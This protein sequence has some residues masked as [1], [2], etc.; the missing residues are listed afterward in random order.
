MLPIYFGAKIQILIITNFQIN[1]VAHLV[2]LQNTD[3]S[4]ILKKKKHSKNFVIDDFVCFQIS[5]YLWCYIQS[6]NGNML[7]SAGCQKEVYI[8]V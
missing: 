7:I 5:Q 2:I 8:E 3:W 1:V 4:R 6:V